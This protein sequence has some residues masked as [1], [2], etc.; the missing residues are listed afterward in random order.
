MAWCLECHF[1]KDL[2]CSVYFVAKNWT[3]KGLFIKFLVFKEQFLAH[4]PL[5]RA[6]Y[7]CILLLLF[8][9]EKTDDRRV[10]LNIYE[11]TIRDKISRDSFPWRA[12]LTFCQLKKGKCFS[13]P[14][15]SMQCCDAVCTCT[16][17]Q[18]PQFWMEGRGGVWIVFFCEVAQLDDNIWTIL[19]SIVDFNKS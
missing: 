7:F 17:Q 2:F 9:C 6:P 18:T 3:P 5:Q 1:A 10:Q 13:F 8:T 15:P 11:A 4:S 19:S 12:S 14:S 16:K